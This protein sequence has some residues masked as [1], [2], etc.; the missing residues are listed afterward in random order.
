MPKRKPQDDMPQRPDDDR[1]E[2]LD[3][4]ELTF[5]EDSSDDDQGFSI[6]DEED[7][8]DDEDSGRAA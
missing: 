8:E 7:D 5:A 1:I 4:D 3:S 2:E 6:S